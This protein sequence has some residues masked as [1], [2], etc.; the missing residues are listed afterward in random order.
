MSLKLESRLS[1]AR[2][3]LLPYLKTFNDFNIAREVEIKKM[4]PHLKLLKSTSK[5]QSKFFPHKYHGIV[6]SLAFCLIL[7]SCEAI[8]AVNEG[9]ITTAT[10][11]IDEKST[12][13][14]GSTSRD[15]DHYDNFHNQRLPT[16]RAEAEG[17]RIEGGRYPRN[18]G[19]VWSQ[20]NSET[21]VNTP[22]VASKSLISQNDTQGQHISKKDKREKLKTGMYLFNIINR[23]ELNSQDLVSWKYEIYARPIYFKFSLPHSN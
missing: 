11:S 21:T 4:G 23:E 13:I 22:A 15:Q 19:W 6:V 9:K 3:L 7:T 12:S 16:I 14:N 17:G 1:R 5:S 10:S 8:A 18:T 2:K 20:Q